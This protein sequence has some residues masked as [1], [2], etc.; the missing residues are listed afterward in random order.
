[1]EDLVR[2]VKI[3]YFVFYPLRLRVVRGRA[4]IDYFVVIAV[5]AVP[6]PVQKLPVYLYLRDSRSAGEEFCNKITYVIF[7]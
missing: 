4:Y 6:V 1:M 3:L 2:K 7:D 5:F